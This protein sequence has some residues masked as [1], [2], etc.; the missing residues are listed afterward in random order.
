MKSAAAFAAGL[1]LGAVAVAATGLFYFRMAELG[2]APAAPT[3]RQALE[4]RI[5]LLQQEQARAQ[6]EDARLKQTIAD[7]QFKLGARATADSRRQF[8]NVRRETAESESPPE[9]W[10]VDA[11][12]KRDAQALPRLER[13]ALENNP[14]A[15]DALALLAEQDNAESL[16]RVWNSGKLTGA[17]RQRAAQLLAA[18]AELNPH[19]EELL[20]GVFANS[21][22]EPLVRDA[23]LAGVL[24]PD[25]ST[26]LR[27]GEPQHF[28]PDYA[29]R[30]RLMDT[31]R[32]AVTNEQ[33]LALLDRVREK[34]APQATGA[35]A[36]PQ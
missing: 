11:V 13:A 18:T 36:P 26:R 9:T 8:R 2:R 24:M 7:L 17:L 16:S 19:V 15:L 6:A 31:W 12:A 1:W 34:L 20:E 27:H 25:F 35:D 28:R 5:Q 10:I 14:V 30:L 32:G 29:F 3:D 21:P 23:A 33:T 22:A 4:M